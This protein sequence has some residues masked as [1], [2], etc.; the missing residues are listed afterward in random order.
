[1]EEKDFEAKLAKLSHNIE[2]LDGK[3]EDRISSLREELK[4]EILGAYFVQIRDAS[5]IA[6]A[7]CKVNPSLSKASDRAFNQITQV[8]SDY[9]EMLDKASADEFERDI[10]RL[11]REINRITEAAGIGKIWK[12]T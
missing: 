8:A 11:K 7:M 1:M 3:L 5:L 6:V 12:E 2:Q 4:K 10:Q 9:K